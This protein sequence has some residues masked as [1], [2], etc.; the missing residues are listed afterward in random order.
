MLFFQINHIFFLLPFIKYIFFCHTTLSDNFPISTFFKTSLHLCTHTHAHILTHTHIHR[1]TKTQIHTQTNTQT[2]THVV[3]LC[4]H[5]GSSFSFWQLF[6]VLFINLDVF[7]LF[8]SLLWHPYS[9]R[10]KVVFKVVITEY[11]H[12]TYLLLFGIY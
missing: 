5:C 9:E 8:F 6:W 7:V 10:R 11:A 12:Y 1:Q 2:L 3:D 4:R